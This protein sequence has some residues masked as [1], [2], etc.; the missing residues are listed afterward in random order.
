MN[1]NPRCDPGIPLLVGEVLVSEKKRACSKSAQIRFIHNSPSLETIQAS[2]NR[3][4]GHIAVY[5]YHRVALRN[6]KGGSVDTGNSMASWK[7]KGARA[8][9]QTLT[10]NVPWSHFDEALE[11][12]LK[13]TAI[14]NSPAGPLWVT[15][16]WKSGTTELSGITETFQ[17]LT[18]VLATQVRIRVYVFMVDT[19]VKCVCF[20]T[21]NYASI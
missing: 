1:H 18:P 12:V 5:S 21:G 13:S 15:T 6:K 9:Y 19:S 3:M 2:V 17:F 7:A 10:L 14:G 11:E 16:A 4:D 8:R 20:T